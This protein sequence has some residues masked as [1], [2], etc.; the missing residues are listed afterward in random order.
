MVILIVREQV[1]IALLVYVKIHTPPISVL[2]DLHIPIAVDS[3]TVVRAVVIACRQVHKE[4]KWLT[5][6]DMVRINHLT[7]IRYENLF[8]PIGL[9]KKSMLD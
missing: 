9:N 3:D 1:G 2:L 4:F 6:D 7:F 5:L 8:I